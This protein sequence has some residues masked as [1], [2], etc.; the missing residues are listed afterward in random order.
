MAFA[1]VHAGAPDAM[2]KTSWSTRLS[3]WRPVGEVTFTPI[4]EAALW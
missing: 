1:A 3:V 2:R 4:V